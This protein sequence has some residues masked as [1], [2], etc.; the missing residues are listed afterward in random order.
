MV[1]VFF[2]VDAASASATEKRVAEVGANVSKAFAFNELKEAAT[3]VFDLLRTGF[4]KF[5][6]VARHAEGEVVRSLPNITFPLDRSECRLRLILEVGDL[7][8]HGCNACPIFVVILPG[9]LDQLLAC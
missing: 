9:A 4:E 1:R 7:F 2:G 6:H 3:G 5:D 8:A